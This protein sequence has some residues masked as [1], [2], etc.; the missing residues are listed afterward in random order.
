M[1][2]LDGQ[3]AVVT[4]AGSGIGRA[5]AI[6]FARE[7]CR[8]ALVG[9]RAEPLAAV[10]AEVTDAG[11][12]CLAVPADVSDQSAVGRAVEQ[13]LRTWSRIDVLVNNA[14][15]NVPRRDVA[16]VSLDDWTTVLAVNLTGTFLLTQAVLPTMRTQGAGTIL[17]VSSI[18]GHR[19]TALTGP[20][21]SAAKAG[22]NSFTESLNLTERVHGIRASAVCPGEVATPI[23]DKRPHPPS[24][25]ARTTMLQPEDLAA[26]LL[27]LATLPQ[28]ATV[29]LVTLFPT[30]PRDWSSEVA[31]GADNGDATG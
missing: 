12:T 10:A 1:G 21:Y 27:F 11:G 23:L 13:V 9:R 4:G 7:G 22:V 19:T 31:T 18:A 15:L 30:A 24:A 29:E 6:A 2:L 25:Q 3:V 5:T 28:R 14:G 20:A 8:V 16:S 17:N 26:T